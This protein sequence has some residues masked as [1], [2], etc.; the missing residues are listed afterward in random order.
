[1]AERAV[2]RT[3]SV[4]VRRLES[5]GVINV[6]F[7]GNCLINSDGGGGGE[8]WDGDRSSV[9]IS[10]PDFLY[11]YFMSQLDEFVWILFVCASLAFVLT[12]YVVLVRSGVPKGRAVLSSALGA[13]SVPG[14]T[15]APRPD[16]S[17]G[18]GEETPAWRQRS[19]GVRLS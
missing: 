7:S 16:P 14:P 10:M 3:R 9:G 2:L 5:D 13:A 19:R 18:A 8:R 17:A 12:W 11:E 1:M 6:R 15:S 4:C